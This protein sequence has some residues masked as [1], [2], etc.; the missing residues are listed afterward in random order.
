M[1]CYGFGETQTL[2]DSSSG[3]YENKNILTPDSARDSV[4]LSDVDYSAIWNRTYGGFDED[5][6]Q[7]LTKCEDGGYALIGTTSSYSIGGRDIWVVRTNEFG[8]VLWTS[9]IGDVNDDAGF[10]IIECDN[11]DFVVVGITFFTSDY[12]ARVDRIDANGNTIWTKWVG[13]NLT[14]DYF[15]DVV[16]SSSGYLVVVGQTSSFGAASSD[17]LVV[18]LDPNGNDVWMRM[19]GGPVDEGAR[20]II[21]CESGGFA[22]VGRTSSSGAG[23]SDVWLLRLDVNGNLLWDE[24]YGGFYNEYGYELIEYILGDFVIVGSTESLGDLAGD[25]W[26]IRVNNL[27]I[28]KW[29]V[30]FDSGGPD[31]ATGIVECVRGGFAVVGIIDH[32]YSYSQIRI[33]RLDTDG[34]EIWTG[35]YG[36][37]QQERSYGIEEVRPE[38]FIVA[39]ITSSYGAGN[40]DA[41]LFLIP[42]MPTLLTYPGD[43]FF[44]YGEF[45]YVDLWV[46]STT[47]I[48]MWWLEDTSVFSIAKVPGGATI[49]TFIPTDVGIYEIHFHANNTAG[50]EVEDWFFIHVID[51]ISPF[52]TA[53]PENKTIEY[54]EMLQYQLHANDLSGLNE[55]TLTGSTEFVINTNGEIA[56]SQIPAVGEYILEVSVNDIYYNTLST[57]LV[58]SVVDTTAPDWIEAPCDQTIT[59]GDSFIYD[60]NATDLSGLFTWWIDDTAR[61]TIDWQGRIRNLV[62]LSIG[63]HGVSVFVADPYGNI[64]HGTFTIVVQGNGQTTTNGGSLDI[65]SSAI[66]FI[67]GVVA[68]AAVVSI[69]I[70]INRKRTPSK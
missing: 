5:R 4:A 66:P 8:D 67:T 36:G 62:P 50:Y 60:L 65:M 68:T 29:N 21:E 28:E 9:V 2:I 34:T 63:S 41:W 19:Y 16:E 13:E 58:V 70:V 61:F 32:G 30:T 54:G 10:A 33:V 44:E 48:D 11:G 24:T 20:S 15:Y 52:W 42:G 17:L 25:Y 69:V 26:I 47:D 49:Y 38:E 7:D 3:V 18:C 56:N 27:G 53:P 31:L 64:L 23:N 6:F 51:S 14:Q 22:I 59:I 1:T 12:D 43:Q 35:F 40:Y 45:P 39:G 46:E 37:P 55:W 57:K